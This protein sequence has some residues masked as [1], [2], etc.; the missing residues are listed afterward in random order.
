M[1]KHIHHDAIIAWANGNTIQCYNKES[2]SWYNAEIPMW[3]AENQ[4]R[5]KPEEEII[6]F[7]TRKLFIND[8]EDIAQKFKEKGIGTVHPSYKE[9]GSVIL[10]YK[11]NELI[12]YH[13]V[14]INRV[15]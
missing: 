6:T 7:T 2:N 10:S 11:D 8:V 5:V 14:I 15:T 1:T 3:I 9:I 13:N 12:S 4:Y